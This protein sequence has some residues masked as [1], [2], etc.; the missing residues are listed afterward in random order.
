MLANNKTDRSRHTHALL[1][2]LLP[3]KTEAAAQP[4]TKISGKETCT[5]NFRLYERLASTYL[6]GNKK[7]VSADDALFDGL[8]NGAT[9]VGLVVISQS[10]VDMPKSDSNS[11]QD[12]LVNL[13]WCRLQ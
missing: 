12:S 4:R 9:H 2:L 13:R 10:A 3:L 7:L 5:L 1:F 11:F 6:A 8:R